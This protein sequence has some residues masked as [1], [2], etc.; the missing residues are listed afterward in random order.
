MLPILFAIKKNHCNF[1]NVRC[2]KFKLFHT[3]FSRSL[4]SLNLGLHLVYKKKKEKTCHSL[5]MKCCIG[6]NLISS[7]FKAEMLWGK[8]IHSGQLNLR[9]I[10]VHIQETVGRVQ[11]WSPKWNWKWSHSVESDSLRPHGLYVAHQAPP[12]MGFSRQ[13]YWSGLPLPSPIQ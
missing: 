12:S 3:K 1:V 6:N 13:E 5:A 4:C 11:G 8:L 9:G 7:V 2:F 10:L